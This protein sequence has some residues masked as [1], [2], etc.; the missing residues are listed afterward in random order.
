[1]PSHM[2]HT[3]HTLPHLTP[4]LLLT[5][6]EKT[7]LSFLSLFPTLQKE[8]NHFSLMELLQGST[9]KNHTKTLAKRLAHSRHSEFNY[10]LRYHHP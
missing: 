3:S 10:H 4:A 1:M 2:P 5:R 9:Q 7:F 6:P 8:E